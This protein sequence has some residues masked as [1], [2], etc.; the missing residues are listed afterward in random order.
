MQSSTQLLL[1]NDQDVM[2]RIAIVESAIH[3]LQQV[4][5]LK[6][7]PAK[8]SFVSQEDGSQHELV[9]SSRAS[10]SDM[11]KSIPEHVR[12]KYLVADGTA[13]DANDVRSLVDAGLYDPEMEMLQLRGHNGNVQVSVLVDGYE[14]DF[15][16]KVVNAE[17]DL[18]GVE[19]IASEEIRRSFVEQHADFI[20]SLGPEPYEIVVYGGV[21]EKCIAGELPEVY[22]DLEYEVEVML[23]GDD[24]KSAS[25][26]PLQAN[27]RM[28]F[29]DIAGIIAEHF[30]LIPEKLS[31]TRNGVTVES[32]QERVIRFG[33]IV[34]DRIVCKAIEA[35][36]MVTGPDGQ[37]FKVNFGRTT[38]LLEVALG[39]N[40]FYGKELFLFNQRDLVRNLKMTVRELGVTALK[41]VDRHSCDRINV[42]IVYGESKVAIEDVPVLSSVGELFARWK[43]QADAPALSG[44]FQFM[45]VKDDIQQRVYENE[46]LCKLRLG[47]NCTELEIYDKFFR[48]FVKTL[49]GKTLDVVT[50]QYDSIDMVKCKIQEM[51]GI[52]P[53][54]QRLIFAGKQL[55]DGRLVDDYNII[56]DST[57]HLVLRLRGGMF[58]PS[59]GRDG[60]SHVR[61][62]RPQS[63]RHNGQSAF[64]ATGADDLFAVGMSGE[65]EGELQ[66]ERG[67]DYNKLDK[68]DLTTIS[69]EEA[70]VLLSELFE[71]LETI[72]SQLGLFLW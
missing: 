15:P 4:V 28:A 54:Q 52:P 67:F 53:D 19:F 64:G 40:Q 33:S 47:E 37:E 55:E 3:I 39:L 38:Q 16:G 61:Q 70:D 26:L 27:Q 10:V 17:I 21:I 22:V 56:P 72:K 36:V 32:M 44:V 62:L 35:F 2:A 69:F 1:N 51:D 6:A 9:V 43:A 13:Y 50:N 49:T 34:E 60:F 31:F 57:L 25:S 7:P 46:L 11:F 68:L 41:A 23:E 63:A 42:T 58:H 12:P 20:A 66:Q 18:S 71:E 48:V 5:V 29:D 8:F 45:H 24:F 59:S 30:D 14:S 65:Q